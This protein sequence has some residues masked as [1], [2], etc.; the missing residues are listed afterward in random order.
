MPQAPAE[1]YKG[2][3]TTANGNMNAQQLKKYCSLSKDAE[4]L[5]F[6]A[7]KHYGLSMRGRTKLLKVARTIADLE[8]ETK[9]C[10]HHIG[11]A[12]HYRCLDKHF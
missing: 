6:S 11:E 8:G 1:R 10:S 3:A 5:L 12:I 7:F 9:I 4:K 2:T